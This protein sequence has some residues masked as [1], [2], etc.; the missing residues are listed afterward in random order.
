[1]KLIRI[2][3]VKPSSIASNARAAFRRGADVHEN[4]YPL[5]ST[6]SVSWLLSFIDAEISDACDVAEG[7]R[8]V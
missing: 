4:P 5:G 1:M 3:E 8:L 6:E 7:F 2:T